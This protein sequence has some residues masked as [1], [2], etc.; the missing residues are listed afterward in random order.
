[1]KWK[2]KSKYTFEKYRKLMDEINRIYFSVL[3]QR[4]FC[5]DVT[6]AMKT[7]QKYA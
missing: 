7:V 3:Q 6:W 2:K 1:M 4:R 5:L